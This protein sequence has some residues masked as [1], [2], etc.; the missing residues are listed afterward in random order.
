M[1]G[2]PINTIGPMTKRLASVSK[3]FKKVKAPEELAPSHAIISSAWELAQNAFTMRVAGGVGQQHR[4]RAARLV[5]RGRRADA[6]SARARGSADHDGAAGRQVITPR[7]IRLLRA[8][9]L[10]GYRSTLVDLARD[11]DPSSA[12]DTFVLV[13]TS[14][15]AEQL[16]RTLDDRLP[17][18]RARAHAGSRSRSVRSPDRA[19]A[20][21][22]APPERHSSAKHC[23]PP[24]PAKPKKAA[25]R[26]RFTCV[27]RSSPRCSRST[28]T[29]PPW[30]Q[31]RRFR[32][33]AERRARTG[34][35][36]GSRRRATARS[37]AI[38][39][40]GVSRL[41]GPA[42]GG[43]RGRRARRAGAVAGDAG[44]DAPAARDRGDRRSAVR[45]RRL[46][47]RGRRDADD[48]CRPRDDR[49]PLDRATCS[50][51]VISIACGWRS[52]R[53]R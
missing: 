5:R 9:D 4:H 13:P 8:P 39:V 19:I 25:R 46:L 28:T 41:R 52:W 2:P 32:S 26:R 14:A 10:A 45:S 21:T 30:P 23:W 11:L 48:D 17:D 50:T 29:P 40:G 3:S 24:A 6:L 20:G 18:H 47:A 33:P 49:H 37:N 42:P 44:G 35:R 43:R 34:G 27:R 51:P 38:P 16:A 53:S 12:A 15:A 31:R 1:S 22:A 36:I 7:R